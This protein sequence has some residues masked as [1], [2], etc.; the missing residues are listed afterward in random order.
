MTNKIII[1]LLIITANFSLSAQTADS[2]STGTS[3]TNDVYYSF[4]NGVVKTS[5]NTNWDL[6][7]EMSG[8]A[9]SILVNHVKGIEL[10]QTPFANAQWATIDTT[11]YKNFKKMY[12]S[13]YTWNLGAFNRHTDGNYDLGWGTYDPNT[14]AVN[15]DSI[16]LIKFADG[17]LKKII[18]LNLISGIYNFKYA[19]IDGSNSKLKSISKTNFKNRNFAYFAFNNDTV[20][21]REPSNADWD[22]IFS[23]YAVFIPQKYNV[24]GIW[25][26][27]NAKCAEA[28][29]VSKEI[30]NYNNFNFS[31]TNSI[32]GYD[33]KKYNMSLGKYDITDSL[34]YF[35]KNSNNAIWKIYFTGYKGGTA[36]TYYFTKQVFVAS[37]NKNNSNKTISIYPNPA[38]NELNI[39]SEKS[40]EN[41]TICSINGAEIIKGNSSKINI[42]E[43]PMGIYLIKIYSEDGIGILKFIKN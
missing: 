20:I 32:I 15:G 39:I 38:N 7:F 34:V 25:T 3:N 31:D 8:M 43:L 6:A 36:G 10:Y 14:H 29:N 19:S 5:S 22:I 33:W 1:I 30:V 23:K 37:V 42:S 11:G 26:N 18:I 9:A 2:V 16:F 40:I 4:E 13:E 17:S 21:D 24:A 28:R 41:Y 35:V 12:N 27:K